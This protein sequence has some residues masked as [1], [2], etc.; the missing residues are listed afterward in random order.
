MQFHATVNDGGDEGRYLAENEGGAR[1][2]GQRTRD[3]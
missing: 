3:K 2:V 1:A